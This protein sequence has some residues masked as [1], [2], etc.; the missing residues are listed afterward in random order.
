MQIVSYSVDTS[1]DFCYAAFELTWNDVKCF[2]DYKLA[3]EIFWEKYFNNEKYSRL[4]YINI[5]VL[6]TL[7]GMHPVPKSSRGML[8][9]ILLFHFRCAQLLFH[10][11]TEK[12]KG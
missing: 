11:I 12:A 4:E 1:L 8:M 2:A 3:K 9:K 10:F 6:A 7:W 5:Q